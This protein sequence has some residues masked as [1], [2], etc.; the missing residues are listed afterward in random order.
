MQNIDYL[1]VTIHTIAFI[2]FDSVNLKSKIFKYS[3]SCCL[4]K[5]LY[6]CILFLFLF[7]YSINFNFH[8]QK[9]ILCS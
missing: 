4:V 1:N 9:Q 5:G 3:I 8:Q 2:I 7:L 6:I